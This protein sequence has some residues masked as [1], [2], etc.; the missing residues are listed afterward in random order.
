MVGHYPVVENIEFLKAKGVLGESQIYNQ[1][2]V[3]AWEKFAG[4]S[5]MLFCRTLCS[6]QFNTQDNKD[7]KKKGM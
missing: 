5:G 3:F 7:I 4:N 6:P 2:E 1:S